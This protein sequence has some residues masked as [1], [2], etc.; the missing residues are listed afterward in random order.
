M[1]HTEGKLT[2]GNN[3]MIRG[4]PF[5]QYFNG[6]VQ[7]QLAMVM[8]VHEDDVEQGI[9]Q[10]DNARRIVACWNACD[11]LPTEVLEAMANPSSSYTAL[12]KERD[13][14]VKALRNVAIVGDLAS[15]CRAEELLLKCGELTK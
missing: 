6:K 8:T 15:L 14:L 9:T 7:S 13:E 1:S 3:G 5:R 4:G 11:G 10:Q 2:L 12:I